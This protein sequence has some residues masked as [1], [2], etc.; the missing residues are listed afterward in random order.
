MQYVHINRN[1]ARLQ[2]LYEMCLSFNNFTDRLKLQNSSLT[3]K[4]TVESTG[5]AVTVN[6]NL[7][8]KLGLIEYM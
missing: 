6:I 8:A 5:I 2:Q 7:A 3:K 1:R 4:N